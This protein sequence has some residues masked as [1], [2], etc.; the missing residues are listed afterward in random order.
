MSYNHGNDIE[1]KEFDYDGMSEDIGIEAID[2]D[3]N[4][5]FSQH[6]NFL[7]KNQSFQ[8]KRNVTLLFKNRK[9]NK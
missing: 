9:W 6:K 4:T 2:D 3:C 1:D 7:Q 5:P 8:H